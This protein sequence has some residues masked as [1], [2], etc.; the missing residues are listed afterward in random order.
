MRFVDRIAG[1]QR[2]RD[3]GS[4]PR[5]VE[6]EGQPAPLWHWRRTLPE[7]AF[8][9][10]PATTRSL[11]NLHDGWVVEAFVEALPPLVIGRLRRH[12]PD[13][14]ITEERADWLLDADGHFLGNALDQV[15]PHLFARAR[16]GLLGRLASRADDAA[17]HARLLRQL[18]G[19]DRRFRIALMRALF[20]GVPGGPLA[21]LGLAPGDDGRFQVV[22][23]DGLLSIV[24]DGALEFAVTID[25]A[26]QAGFSPGWRASHVVACF[27]PLLMVELRGDDGRMA[28]W[29]LDAW[30]DRVDDD[31]L[32]RPATIE[33]LRT[34]A[35]PMIRRHWLQVLSLADCEPGYDPPPLCSGSTGTRGTPCSS[36]CATS[37]CRRRS[38]SCWASSTSRS[39]CRRRRAGRPSWCCPSSTCGR[40]CGTASTRPGRTPSAADAWSGRA[41]STAATP[42][43]RRCS[44]PR[45]T[46]SSTSSGTATA[47]ASWS[48]PA[49]ATAS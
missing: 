21:A 12:R 4:E 30:F 15:P 2:Q 8:A 1:V 24:V 6:P 39:C 7:G 23:A 37:S 47:S 31:T 42:S 10:L 32:A 19:L 25:G 9:T 18:Q 20:A 29:V 40:R 17:A 46:R 49:S 5:S 14:G 43:S 41:P 16:H 27:A 48:P 35:P 22:D 11:A 28:T 13:G 45:T 34:V 33:V 36:A 3:G 26:Q 44:R 38:T